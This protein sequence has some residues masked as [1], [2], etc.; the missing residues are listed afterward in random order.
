MKDVSSADSLAGFAWDLFTAWQTAGAPSK[1]SW[2]FTALGVL[3]NDD[4]A[5]KLTPLIRAWPGE[6]QHKRATVGL[7][8]LAA[9][10][11]DIALMQLNGIAQKLKFK[12][13]QERAEEKLPTLP[14]AANSRWRSLKIGWHRISVW[15][16]TVRCCWILAHGSPPSALMKP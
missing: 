1:E 6:S 4:T 16:I 8:I 12:A 3:G 5:R 9:I 10:G 15:M 2:A 7:D 14:R 11:S 13:L